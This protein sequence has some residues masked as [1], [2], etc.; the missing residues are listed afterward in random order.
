MATVVAETLYLPSGR[1]D[2]TSR[3]KVVQLMLLRSHNQGDWTAGRRHE[4][5]IGERMSNGARDDGSEQS[6]E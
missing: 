4:V 2:L 1:S 6:I 5:R 3:M